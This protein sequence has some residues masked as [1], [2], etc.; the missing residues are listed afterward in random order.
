M[1][2]RYLRFTDLAVKASRATAI[3]VTHIN[4]WEEWPFIQDAC[5]FLYKV[6]YLI[7]VVRN[8]PASDVIL[9]PHKRFLAGSQ[10]IKIKLY[11]KV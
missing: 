2:P 7:L 10:I 3:H 9:K 11:P 6:E 4:C 8:F 5:S 1:K